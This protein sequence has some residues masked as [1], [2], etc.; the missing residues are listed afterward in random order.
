MCWITS[1]LGNDI[2]RADYTRLCLECLCEH[3]FEGCNPWIWARM[4]EMNGEN[5]NRTPRRA[6]TRSTCLESLVWE[7]QTLLEGCQLATHKCAYLFDAIY[8]SDC[9]KPEARAVLLVVR[10]GVI[11]WQHAWTAKGAAQ[12]LWLLSKH[13][14]FYLESL[15]SSFIFMSCMLSWLL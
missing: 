12:C 3:L 11:F 1:G 14:I 7:M 8:K 2:A 10:A 4:W 15:R 5:V 9:L 13:S 6:S